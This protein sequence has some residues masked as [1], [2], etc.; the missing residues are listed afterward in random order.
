MRG[1]SL[2][3]IGRIGGW[4]CAAVL[5]QACATDG[6]TPTPKPTPVA[7][8][9]APAP[10]PA[11]AAKPVNTARPTPAPKPEP[12]KPADVA[13]ALS[14]G[15]VDFA[16]TSS[17]DSL[18]SS[19]LGKTPPVIKI[20]S[21]APMSPNAIPPRL[22]KWFSAVVKSGGTVKLQKLP[23]PPPPGQPASR[24]FLFEIVDLAFTIY[25]YV[26]EMVLYAPAEKYN[27]VVVYNGSQIQDIKFNKRDAAPVSQN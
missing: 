20:S 12:V 7:A 3:S 8:A 25:D 6:S 26:H 15:A 22:E 5:L 21:E 23:P 16:D 9:P 2:F 10:P 24:G 13:K 19:S 4:L 1:F 17:F 27:V 14:N 11:P 18:L